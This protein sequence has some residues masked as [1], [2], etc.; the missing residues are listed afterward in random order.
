M[1]PSSYIRV[2]EYNS[3]K[4]FC[5]FTPDHSIDII[6]NFFSNAFYAQYIKNH[7]DLTVVPKQKAYHLVFL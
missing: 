4:N 6:C 5:K 1:I 3:Q 2:S 7:D